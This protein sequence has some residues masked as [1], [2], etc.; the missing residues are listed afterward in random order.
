MHAVL[1]LFAS[2]VQGVRATFGMRF[3]CRD[4]DWHT[5][6]TSE[7]L[8]QTKPDIQNQEPITPTDL[9]VRLPREGGD[10]AS[11]RSAL[12]TRTIP[13]TVIPA[14][15][16]QR[17]ELEP[18]SHAHERQHVPPLDSGSRS[19]ASGMTPSMCVQIRPI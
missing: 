10:P 2:L 5:D 15:A 13:S 14:E 18:R 11:A 4:L 9:Q 1:M 7:A 19:R 12:P 17:A 3:N 6:E 16:R 8:P